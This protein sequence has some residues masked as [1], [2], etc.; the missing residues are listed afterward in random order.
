MQTNRNHI[1]AHVG[2]RVR[3][4][5][6]FR[7][8][9]LEDLAANA[10]MTASALQSCEAGLNR[11]SA[12]ELMRISQCLRVEVSFFFD[13]FAR[14]RETPPLRAQLTLMAPTAEAPRSSHLPQF[15]VGSLRPV[16]ARI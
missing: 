6:V 2:D 15:D 12:K 3:R 1:D 11:F 16:V 14:K 8:I 10:E 13:G 7:D 9:N 5:R 4:A